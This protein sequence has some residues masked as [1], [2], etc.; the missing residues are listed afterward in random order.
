M[1]KFK[2]V[3]PNK[4]NLTVQD[5]KNLKIIDESKISEPLFWRNNVIGAWCISKSV[6]T[7]ADWQFSTDNEIWLGIYDRCYR[8]SRIHFRV[9][10]YGGMCSYSFNRFYDPS[11]IESELDFK[12]HEE[13]LRILNYLLDEQILCK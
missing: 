4:Y 8:G 9:S 12:T 7:V 2:I 11:E 13:C 3:V 5:I 10:A 6:G 1:K